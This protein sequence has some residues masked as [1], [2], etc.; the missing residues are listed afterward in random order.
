MQKSEIHVGKEYALREGRNPDAPIQRIK[1]IKHIRGRKWKAKWIDPNPGLEDY[2][3]T[4]NLLV[5]WKELKSFLKDEEKARQLRKDNERH[6]YQEESPVGRVL[7]EIFESLGES[8]LSFYR[9]VLSGRPDALDR[10]RKRAVY[11]PDKSSPFTYVDR[12]GPYIFHIL[13][14]LNLPRHFADQNLIQSY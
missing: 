6:G 2:I 3:E 4:Q 14:P 5:P 13:K 12:H 1:I 9:G 10:V 11:D 8:D 7:Y